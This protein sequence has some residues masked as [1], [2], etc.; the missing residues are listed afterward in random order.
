MKEHLSWRI[1]LPPS[2]LRRLE[3]TAYAYPESA[4]VCVRVIHETVVPDGSMAGTPVVVLGEIRRYQLHLHDEISALICRNVGA[5]MRQQIVG[6]AAEN[7]IHSL[8]WHGLTHDPHFRKAIFE[9]AGEEYTRHVGSLLDL[10]ADE[11]G[12]E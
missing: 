10:P 9:M 8:F 3:L 5:V 6:A 7:A 12:G 2:Y 11:K 4:T 1:K